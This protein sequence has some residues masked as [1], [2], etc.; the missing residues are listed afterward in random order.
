MKADLDRSKQ[1]FEESQK[2]FNCEFNQKKK[3]A[4]EKQRQS[5]EASSET[6]NANEPTKTSEPEKE[7]SNTELIIIENIAEPQ[8]RTIQTPYAIK[9]SGKHIFNAICSDTAR[10]FR[11]VAACFSVH[12]WLAKSGYRL[13]K[14]DSEKSFPSNAQKTEEVKQTNCVPKSV[15]NKEDSS[16]IIPAASATVSDESAQAANQNCTSNSVS[17]G[18]SEDNQLSLREKAATDSSKLE[19]KVAAATEQDSKSDRQV[20]NPDLQKHLIQRLSASVEKASLHPEKLA[21]MEM[22]EEIKRLALG[23][24][25][26][27]ETSPSSVTK[28]EAKTDP[29]ARPKVTVEEKA[30]KKSSSSNAPISSQRVVKDAASYKSEAAE[31]VQSVQPSPEPK[32]RGRKKKTDTQSS[33]T[34]VKAEAT[35]QTK[36]TVTPITP[37]SPKAN[38]AAK[39]QPASSAQAK[40]VSEKTAAAQVKAK[41]GRK[42]KAAATVKEAVQPKASI[43]SKTANGGTQSKPAVKPAPKTS[44]AKAAASKTPQKAS[45]SQPPQKAKQAVAPAA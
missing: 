24:K 28:A 40:T 37:A 32:K 36:Q 22:D 14:I 11:G 44:V 6:I 38:A 4:K 17:T 27:S 2:K 1:E 16:L 29:A 26:S 25:S 45:A 18:T 20:A 7:M 41:P 13:V 34:S 8:V 5:Q 42:P 15:E 9:A 12:N 21:D 19:V 23:E 43:V 33:N 39:P 3:K 35:T 31:T 10:F 30:S